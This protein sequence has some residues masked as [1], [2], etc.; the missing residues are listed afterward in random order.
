M[1]GTVIDIYNNRRAKLLSA[2]DIAFFL[3]IPLDEAR[4]LVREMNIPF[5][6]RNGSM[7]VPAG[8]FFDW[9]SYTFLGGVA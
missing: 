1:K 5:E 3:N 2:R 8:A 7:R 9:Y 4:A 6:I